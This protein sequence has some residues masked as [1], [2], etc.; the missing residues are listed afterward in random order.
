MLNTV[1]NKNV[2]LN[3]SKEK[4]KRRLIY[5]VPVEP[6]PLEPLCVSSKS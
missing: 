5:F 4:K 1:L 6:K 2:T 3:G